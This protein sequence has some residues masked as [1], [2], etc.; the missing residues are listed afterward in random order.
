MLRYPPINLKGGKAQA[1]T[2]AGAG[3]AGGERTQPSGTTGTSGNDIKTHT[4][5]GLRKCSKCTHPLN[6]YDSPGRRIFSLQFVNKETKARKNSILS[7][8]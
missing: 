1:G 6:S 7:T 4:H 2:Q 8:N 3:K 5:R